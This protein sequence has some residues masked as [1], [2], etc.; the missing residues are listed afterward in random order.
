[1]GYEI[2]DASL[3]VIGS[4][5]QIEEDGKPQLSSGNKTPVG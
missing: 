5:K 4:Q 2:V 1:M 3:E